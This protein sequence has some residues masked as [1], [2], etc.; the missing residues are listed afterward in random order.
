[1]W[2]PKDIQVDYTRYHELSTWYAGD[3][4]KLAELY[5]SSSGLDPLD[6]KNSASALRSSIAESEL[7]WFWGTPPPAGEKLTKLHL[8]IASDIATMS[9]DLLFSEPPTVTADDEATQDRVDWLMDEG[10]VQSRLLGAAEVCS[11]LGDV[12]LVV[13]WDTDLRDHPWLRVVHA[14][15]VAPEWRGD[16]LSAATIWTELESDGPRV[17]R[18]LERYEDGLILHGLYRGDIRSLGEKLDLAEHPATER[19]TDEIRTGVNGMLIEHVPNMLPNRLHRG[20]NLGR[21]DYS[22]GSMQ[23]MDQLDATWSSLSREFDLCKARAVVTADSP[24]VTP[25]GPGQ[26]VSV[27]L[28]RRIFVP[29]PMSP[30]E[31]PS[32]PVKL[33]QPLIR[34]EEHLRGCAG[35]TDQIIR[36]CGYSAQSFGLGVSEVAVTATE[37]QARTGM[38]F[39][40]RGKKTLHWVALRKS[41][42]KLL[43]VD[44]AVFHTATK[45]G[46]LKV[47]FGDSISESMSTTAQTLSMLAQAEAASI[48]QRVQILHPEWDETAVREE[49]DRIY[50]ETGR[51]VPDPESVIGGVGD[52]RP[53]ME[54]QV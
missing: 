46:R 33:I 43:D 25:R 40:T 35:F 18:H 19:F 51:S 3:P 53:V 16:V 9:A 29:I 13:A 47:E 34:V 32:D 49:V 8:P 7:R 36:S 24:A 4:M 31:R 15:A 44:R 6:Q 23:F 37:V 39:M 2:P 5:G 50:S 30:M 26:G 20:S 22:P 11:A 38:S 54:E 14:D 28:D 12:Y 42:E 48:R 17:W 10:G 52:G 45:P 27:D 41:M 1:M 21:S